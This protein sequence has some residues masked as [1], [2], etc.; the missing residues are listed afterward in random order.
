[1]HPPPTI[2]AVELVAMVAGGASGEP[3]TALIALAC[4]PLA[5]SHGEGNLFQQ[6]RRF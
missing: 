2:P 6:R 1:M 4:V 3:D 5:W